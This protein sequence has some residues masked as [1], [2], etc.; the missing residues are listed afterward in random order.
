MV[1]CAA[2][3]PQPQASGAAAM[4]GA[5]PR[6]GVVG[7]GTYGQQILR[8]F[9]AEARRGRVTLVALCDPHA[10]RRAR[11]EAE[12][13]LPG[14]AEAGQMMQNCALDAVAVATPD[15]LH[16]GVIETAARHGLHVMVEKPLDVDLA[17]ATRLADSFARANR[18]LY[19][20]QHKRFDPG[21]IRLRQDLAA[22]A[23]GRPLYGSVHME[24]RIEVP[25]IWLRDWVGHS[26]PSWFLGVNFYD[27]VTWLTGL[28]PRRVYATGQK[29]VLE[30]RGLPGVWDSVQAKVDYDTGF[31]MHYDLSWILPA[32]FPSIVN[33]GI[34]IVGSEG[35]AE[36]DSQ[37]RGYFAARADAPGALEGNPF[38][39]LEHDHPLFGPVTD[40][41]VFEAIRHFLD[42]L[43]AWRDGGSARALAGR[44]PDAASALTAIRLA[45]AVDRSL[46]S[47]GIEPV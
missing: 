46:A 44:Y 47:G 13:G 11:A 10:D 32:S 16:A 24:D 20:D 22:G 26:S 7:C 31:S 28:A 2:P 8:C 33:Q 12:F 23:F 3:A 6:L 21:H 15:H 42:V 36:V 18:I 5:A 17:R 40:G 37:Q 19:V 29:G 39:V 30:Q 1:R 25:E 34:R 35:L 43:A 38:G 27:L 45:E 41:Y 14:F 4:S 9:A